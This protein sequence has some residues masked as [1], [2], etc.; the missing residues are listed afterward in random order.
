MH[1]E[2]V[3]T[4]TAT[5]LKTWQHYKCF[6]RRPRVQANHVIYCRWAIKWNFVEQ[7]DG[8]MERIIR[9][10]LKVRVFK[11]RD[12]GNLNSYACAST[13]LSQRLVTSTAA[14]RKW[15]L[16]SVDVDKACLQGMTY[17]EFS[18]LTREHVRGAF[19]Y[20]S[21]QLGCSFDIATC[22]WRFSIRPWRSFIAT[23]LAQA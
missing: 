5:E 1:C 20:A 2:L 18:R 11:G 3:V 12:A 22:F 15:P 10:W 9:A 4:A 19:F 8:T 21:G 14:L 7:Q 16:V 13:C 6:S 23:S 17:E